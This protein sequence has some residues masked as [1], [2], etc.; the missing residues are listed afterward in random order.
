[1]LTAGLLW[2]I[3]HALINNRLRHNLWNINSLNRQHVC[4]RVMPVYL[5]AVSTAVAISHS[6]GRDVTLQYCFYKMG[7][8]FHQ[9]LVCVNA[10][11]PVIS[12]GASPAR[13]AQNW[14]RPAHEMGL[15]LHMVWARKIYP[16]KSHFGPE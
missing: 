16:P 5:T 9:W 3:G 6:S 14:L 12:P 11:Q 13:Q 2:M 15:S 4:M 7:Q 10:R 1:M 8:I